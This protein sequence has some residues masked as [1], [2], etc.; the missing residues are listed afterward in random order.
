ME[1]ILELVPN[2]VF[3]QIRP[4]NPS[5][6]IHMNEQDGFIYHYHSMDNLYKSVKIRKYFGPMTLSNIHR[7]CVLIDTS[8]KHTAGRHLFYTNNFETLGYQQKRTN[9][10]FLMGCYLILRQDLSPDQTR[11]MLHE[12]CESVSPFTDMEG[13]TAHALTLL[14]CWQALYYG[15]II[16]Q[17][18]QTRDYDVNIDL[19][20]GSDE[21]INWV[22]PGKLLALEDPKEPRYMGRGPRVPIAYR[23]YGL[24]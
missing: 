14:D 11:V 12:V 18:F 8:L 16:N 7:H 2:R 23:S 6:G 24:F 20:D 1:E 5:S 15:V 4:D 3:F 13:S 21:V 17:W 22:I 9:A 10:V 19:G